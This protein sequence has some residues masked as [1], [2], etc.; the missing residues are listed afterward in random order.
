MRAAD[1][2]HIERLCAPL[3]IEVEGV[4]ARRAEVFATEYYDD[5][6]DRLAGLRWAAQVGSPRRNRAGYGYVIVLH[7]PTDIASEVLHDLARR[8]NVTFP[9]VRYVAYRASEEGVRPSEPQVADERDDRSRSQRIKQVCDR[10]GLEFDLKTAED[11]TIVVTLR[12]RPGL[13]KVLE[14]ERALRGIVEDDWLI[15]YEPGD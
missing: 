11:D 4:Y 13:A 14:A 2:R 15:T 7:G 5:H 10:F 6:L 3:G 9:Y 12:G 1:R 8:I